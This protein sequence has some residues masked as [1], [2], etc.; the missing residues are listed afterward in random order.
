V[1]KNHDNQCNRKTKAI[2]KRLRHLNLEESEG[3]VLQT[4]GKAQSY[5]AEFFPP[6]T[7]LPKEKC[8]EIPYTE[9]LDSVRTI[10]IEPDGR[11]AICKNFYVGNAFEKDII[12]ILRDYDPFKIPEAKAILQG[13]MKGLMEWAQKKGV[14]KK[15]EGYYTTCH[16]CTDL[17]ERVARSRKAAKTLRVREDR[18]DC[19]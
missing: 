16:M 14:R 3:N 8:G 9:A 17:R 13:D 11:V 1:S 12:S 6:R 18:K 5:L 4:E 19:K 2:L 10:S 15:A 7:S